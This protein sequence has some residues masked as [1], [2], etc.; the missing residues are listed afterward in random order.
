MRGVTLNTRTS[1]AFKPQHQDPGVTPDP[2]QFSLSGAAGA[3]FEGVQV[4]AP[5]YSGTAS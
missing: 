1:V 2:L 5:D 3:S 4:A